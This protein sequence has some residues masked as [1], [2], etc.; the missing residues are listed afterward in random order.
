MQYGGGG[1][2]YMFYIYAAGL[3]KFVLL[4]SFFWTALPELEKRLAFIYMI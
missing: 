1:D 3:D 2:F 4:D